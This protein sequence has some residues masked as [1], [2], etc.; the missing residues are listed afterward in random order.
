MTWAGYKSD[1][2]VAGARIRTHTGRISH[3]DNW[4]TVYEL[5]L[6]KS[7]AYESRHARDAAAVFPG[8]PRVKP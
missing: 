4:S 8:V 6:S 2:Y 5:T 1:V 3:S 7:G